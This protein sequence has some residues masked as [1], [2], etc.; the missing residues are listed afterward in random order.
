MQKLKT[1]KVNPYKYKT[2]A[3]GIL[4]ML[5]EGMSTKEITQRMAVSPSYVHTLKKK[6]AH[7][8]ENVLELTEDMKEVLHKASQGSG[9][10][11]PPAAEEAKADEV[12]TVLNARADQYGSF[13]QSADTAIRVKGI[14]HNAIARNDANL[15]PDQILAIDMHAEKLRRIV[16]GN[17][18]HR[19]SWLDIAGYAKLVA[20]RLGGVSR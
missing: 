16:N 11:A 20:D 6:M 1:S 8:A 15:F 2:K 12:D 5:N 17:A 9:K 14:M 3:E 4:A 10:D 7:R 19:D 13:M 18:S